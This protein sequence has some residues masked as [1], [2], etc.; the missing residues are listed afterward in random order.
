MNTALRL[1]NVRIEL[2]EKMLKENE[3]RRYD[4]SI[5]RINRQ[6]GKKQVEREEFVKINR[7]H[8]LRGK[9]CFCLKEST[10]TPVA[11]LHLAIRTLL[12][13][14][15]QVETKYVKKDIVRDYTK[16]ESAAYGPLTRNGY[17]PDKLTDKYLVKSRFLDTYTGLLE[18]ESTLP[19]NALKIRLPIPKRISSTKDGYLKRKFRRERDLDNIMK[20]RSSSSS[21]NHR[22]DF[23]GIFV[24]TSLVRRRSHWKNR[25]H[26]DS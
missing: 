3:A 9:S 20:V 5:E 1:Q 14:R 2:L 10:C 7:L 19:S 8:Y 6:W 23:N 18:L 24:R 17:F 12:R 4:T 22:Q 13:K 16:Y 26:C 25:N 11:V 21:L 15:S